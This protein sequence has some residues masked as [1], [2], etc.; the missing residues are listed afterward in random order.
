MEINWDGIKKFLGEKVGDVLG[1]VDLSKVKL[2]DANA[3]LD[4]APE[5]KKLVTAG[6][7]IVLGLLAIKLFSNNGRF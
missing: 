7:L 5:T 3:N 2:P 4:L 1:E 6:F